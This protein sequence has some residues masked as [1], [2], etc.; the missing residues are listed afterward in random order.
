MRNP[1]GLLQDWDELRR[2]SMLQRP[3]PDALASLSD[4]DTIDMSRARM[5]LVPEPLHQQF[6]DW[7]AHRAALELRL[8]VEPVRACAAHPQPGEP[9]CARQALGAEHQQGDEA[10]QK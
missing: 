8:D 7:A 5:V 10:D 6:D 2:L 1:A 3:W 4:K 9:G